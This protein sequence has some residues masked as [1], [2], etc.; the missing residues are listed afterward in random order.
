M[1]QMTNLGSCFHLPLMVP[2]ASEGDY[3]Y[4]HP[5]RCTEAGTPAGAPKRRR[6]KIK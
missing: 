6:I 2:E 4:G 1:V 3:P 5:F